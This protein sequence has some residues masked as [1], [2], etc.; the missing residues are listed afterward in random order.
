MEYLAFR[1]PD[2]PVKKLVILLHGYSRNADYMQK[3]ADEVLRTVP[4][5]M[6]IC[7]HGIEELEA[8]GDGAPDGEI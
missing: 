6:A 3:M 4:E 8:S 2:K 1:Q 7:P 5:A